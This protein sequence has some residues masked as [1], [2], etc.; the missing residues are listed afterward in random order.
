MDLKSSSIAADF[1]RLTG[2]LIVIVDNH[3]NEEE[4][5]SMNNQ[6]NSSGSSAT[7]GNKVWFSKQGSR[8]SVHHSK[9]PRIEESH[10]KQSCD[11]CIA[12]SKAMFVSAIVKSTAG[13][14]RHSFC[15]TDSEVSKSRT[16][17][18]LR[19]MKREFVRT[20]DSALISGGVSNELQPQ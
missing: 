8:E 13:Q 7:S 17:E 20:F 9:G 1:G 4:H 18:K 10:C 11:Q 6:S 5:H 14:R 15:K 19:F 16:R 2:I 3:S 12:A